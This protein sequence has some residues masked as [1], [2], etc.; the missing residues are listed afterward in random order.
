MVTCWSC[1]G[2][3]HGGVAYRNSRILKI[4]DF[5]GCWFQHLLSS[6]PPINTKVPASWEATDQVPGG[7]GCVCVWL[8]V[9]RCVGVCVGGCVCVGVC[10]CKDTCPKVG[11]SW[12][13]LYIYTYIYIY[14]AV[15]GSGPINKTQKKK[16]TSHKPPN[17]TPPLLP[18]PCCPGLG[19]PGVHHG[20][21][22]PQN[23][24]SSLKTSNLQKLE[25]CCVFQIFHR[26]IATA[27]LVASHCAIVVEKICFRP[28]TSTGPASSI[29]PWYIS[30]S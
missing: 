25:N 24:P 13:V 16:Q 8:S 23:I 7:K 5:E 14:M 17:H 10:V 18:P 2:G 22:Y 30:M 26:S 11:R 19:D 3:L 12:G 1:A 29:I 28:P 9:C 20:H 15:V 4:C 27:N 21:S 6:L